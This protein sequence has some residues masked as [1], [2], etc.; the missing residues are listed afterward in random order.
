MST[1]G[2]FG[3][4]GF[5]KGAAGL[6]AAGLLSA[7]TPG[8]SAP[9]A[10]SAAGG[11]AIKYADEAALFRYMTGGYAAPGPEDDMVKQLQEEILRDEYGINVDIRYE[12]ATWADIDALMEVR[13]QTQG[14]DGLQ[15][16]HR[17]VLR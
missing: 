3:R 10:P 15:R 8:G 4:R 9:A 6:G 5:L 17:A 13:L 2:R 16:H 12:S 1:F 14:V 11:P 7:C